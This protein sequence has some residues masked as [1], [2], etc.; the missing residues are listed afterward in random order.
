MSA[1]STVI[2]S[3]LRGATSMV[4]FNCPA[5]AYWKPPLRARPVRPSHAD[6]AARR[7]SCGVPSSSVT[8][9]VAA[10]GSATPLPPEAAP[11]TVTFLSGESAALATAVIV[12]RPVLAVTPAA[13]VSVAAALRLKS[14]ARA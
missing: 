1:S 9:R 3:S 8:V 2:G 6:P 13:M 11:V 12:T 10:A 14:A 7:A 4:K 5:L